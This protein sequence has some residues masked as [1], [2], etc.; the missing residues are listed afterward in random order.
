MYDDEDEDEDG[1][2]DGMGGVTDPAKSRMSLGGHRH[3][4]RESGVEKRG[5]V[6]KVGLE[7]EVYRDAS[8]P[9]EVSTKVSRVDA[10]AV[11]LDSRNITF[12]PG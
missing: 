10:N 11:C 12:V 2:D 5:N 3:K 9:V 7:V 6:T 8:G 4:G 1:S